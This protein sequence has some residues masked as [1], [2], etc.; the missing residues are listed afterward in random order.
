MKC[1]NHKDVAASAECGQCKK[2]LCRLCVQPH[3]SSIFCSDQCVKDF[4]AAEAIIESQQPSSR[5]IKIKLT[6]MLSL[7]VVILYIAYAYA[8]LEV[9]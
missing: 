3:G 8:G 2:Q 4:K 9:N 1:I 5:K 6:I 7:I